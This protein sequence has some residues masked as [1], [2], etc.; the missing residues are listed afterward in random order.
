MMSGRDGGTEHATSF[1]ARLVKTF[2]GYVCESRSIIDERIS[3]GSFDLRGRLRRDIYA[4][5]KLHEPVTRLK[6]SNTSDDG[7]GCARVTSATDSAHLN[8]KRRGLSEAGHR[9]DVASNCWLQWLSCCGVEAMALIVGHTVDSSYP[10]LYSI[11][12]GS[13]ATQ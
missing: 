5:I 3:Q 1:E 9:T 4:G 8:T 11:L 13:Y 6:S 2:F 12:G 7:E 10:L